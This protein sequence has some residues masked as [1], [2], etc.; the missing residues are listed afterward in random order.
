MVDSLDFIAAYRATMVLAVHWLATKIANDSR[1]P[2]IP[3]CNRDPLPVSFVHVPAVAV[4]IGAIMGADAVAHS[5]IPLRA[6]NSMAVQ[7]RQSRIVK[8]LFMVVP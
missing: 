7:S 6:A 1:S 2:A 3:A 4:A 5:V 8:T